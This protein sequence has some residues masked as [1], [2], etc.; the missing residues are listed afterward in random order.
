MDT[1]DTVDINNINIHANKRSHIYTYRNYIH[2]YIHTYTQTHTLENT[3][4]HI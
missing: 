4:I 3:Y 1:Y 2:T